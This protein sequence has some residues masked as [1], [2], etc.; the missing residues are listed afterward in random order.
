M[1]KVSRV[2]TSQPAVQRTYEDGRRYAKEDWGSF[3]CSMGDFFG[4]DLEW[5]QFSKM[6]EILLGKLRNIWRQLA[7]DIV[8]SLI[9]VSSDLLFIVFHLIETNQG[10]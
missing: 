1:Y 8:S 4:F 10:N 7:E 5:L 2:K 3:L 9:N 6:H